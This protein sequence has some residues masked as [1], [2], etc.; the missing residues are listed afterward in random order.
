MYRTRFRNITGDK[1]NDDRINTIALGYAS[2]NI[3]NISIFHNTN[4]EKTDEMSIIKD[5]RK[6]KSLNNIKYIG[7]HYKNTDNHSE[8]KI[9]SKTKSK[10]KSK[11]KS[12]SKSKSKS[13]RTDLSKNKS[14]ERDNDKAFEN[15]RDYIS[16]IN[17]LNI[18][19]Q[20]YSKK[21]LKKYLE[22]YFKNQKKCQEEIYNKKIDKKIKYHN[23]CVTNSDDYVINDKHCNKK[24]RNHKKH[25]RRENHEH[26]KHHELKERKE[27]HKKKDNENNKHS[28]YFNNSKGNR[29]VIKKINNYYSS[30]KKKKCNDNCNCSDNKS[31]DKSTNNSTN[32]YCDMQYSN[33]YRINDTTSP[34]FIRFKNDMQISYTIVG[35]GGSGGI[36][37]CVK[38]LFFNG[39]GGCAGDTKQG[40]IDVKKHD[41]WKISLGKGGC[42]K[43][44]TNGG[45][46][47]IECYTNC[48][49]TWS[50]TVNGGMNASP[51]LH[52]VL[53]LTQGIIIS[54][55]LPIDIT[56]PSVLNN[57][58]IGGQCSPGDILVIPTRPGENGSITT[59]S[60]QRGTP[61]IGGSSQNTSN[62]GEKGTINNI[63]GHDGKYG[64]GGGGSMCN[65]FDNLTTQYSGNGGDG[66]VLIQ[67]IPDINSKQ[68]NISCLMDISKGGFC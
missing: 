41:I 52:Q 61:G 23:Q 4:H 49:K 45:T 9:K 63:C 27:K 62:G 43:Q 46:T 33:T 7:K 20:N 22:E 40:I 24:N 19:S 53:E 54:G 17:L 18:T 60:S 15:P 39:G 32:N 11:H 66:Y 3:N 21:Y 50:V 37:F 26:Q 56:S 6:D 10:S 29:I 35:G 44:F 13:K 48:I 34:T 1:Y 65:D 31:I 57:L 5:N 8:N 67:C 36:G 25:E 42:S 12:K 47:T 55:K 64:S 28:I 38:T 16:M 2:K 58:V 59:I 68:T 14:C 51:N 30:D